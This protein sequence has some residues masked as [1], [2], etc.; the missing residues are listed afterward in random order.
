M[1]NHT[2]EQ[3]HINMSH[4]KSSSKAEETV[5]KYLF[6]LGFRYRKNDRRF[7]GKPDIVLPKF[8]TIIFINGCFWHQHTN[9]K[10]ASYPKSNQDYWIPKLKKNIERDK[11]NRKILEDKGWNVITIWEC[12]LKKDTIE[13]T[14]NRL[15]EEL[16]S[17]DGSS[18]KKRRNHEDSK[19]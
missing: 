7:A 1:D 16:H 14:L 19:L 9:C 13:Q 4:I 17:R 2:A 15:V 5:R 10:Y 8:R 12:E 11:S 3:R 6:S 18:E